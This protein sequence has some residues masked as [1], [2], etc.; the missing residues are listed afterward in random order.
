MFHYLFI[1]MYMGVFLHVFEYHMYTLPPET[2]VTDSCESPSECWELNPCLLQEQPVLLAAK[3]FLQP[4][5]RDV[6]EDK[7]TLWSVEKQK[8]NLLCVSVG[9]CHSMCGGQRTTSRSH[10]AFSILRQGPLISHA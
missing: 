5:E 1:F 2:G 9:A 6:L 10:F 7:A 8:L 3:L 4:L